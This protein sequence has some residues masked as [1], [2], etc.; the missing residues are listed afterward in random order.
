MGYVRVQPRVAHGVMIDE[1]LKAKELYIVGTK[2]DSFNQ[3]QDASSR[4][5][6]SRD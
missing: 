5:L 1:N 2:E 3:Y 4:A 6:G